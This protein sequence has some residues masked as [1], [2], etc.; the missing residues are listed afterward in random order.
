LQHVFIIGLTPTS[1]ASA[2]Q[3]AAARIGIADERRPAYVPAIQFMYPSRLNNDHDSTLHV[4]AVLC[5]PDFACTSTVPT[6]TAQTNM[7][8]TLFTI[9]LTDDDGGRRFG[10]CCRFDGADGMASVERVYKHVCSP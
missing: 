9:T 7:A 1:S 2:S 5:L 6:Q 8:L 4:I 10:Y 3:L